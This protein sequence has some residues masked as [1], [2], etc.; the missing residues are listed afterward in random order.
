MEGV[1]SLGVGEPDFTT[2]WNIREAAIYSLEKGYTMYTSNSGMPELRQELA[3]YLELHYGVDYHPDHEIL[4]TSGSSEGLDLALRAIVNPGDEVIV[5]DPCYVAYPADI[6]LAG[7]VPVRVPTNEKNDFMVRATDI[8]ARITKRTK[9]IMPVHM[10]GIPCDMDRIMAAARRHKLLVIEDCAQACGGSYKG[11]RLGSIGDVGCFSLQQYKVMT[12][13]EGGMVVINRDG[14]RRTCVS[15]RDWG[16]DCWC[17][18]G[19]NNTCGKRFDWQL[20]DLPYGYDHKYI[21]SNLGYN[22]KVSEMQ[23]A[24]MAPV[25]VPATK[26]K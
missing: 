19:A 25:L 20:G 12:A 14:L 5:P 11:R 9:A 26:S 1:I 17:E 3:G 6:T 2:P 16:R 15:L 24:M 8:E 10:R 21:Y 22:L 13:G 4:I 23:A 7:G 18:P